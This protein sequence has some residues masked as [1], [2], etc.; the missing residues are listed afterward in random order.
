[1]RSHEVSIGIHLAA[2]RAAIEVFLKQSHIHTYTHNHTH[3]ITHTYT[4]TK[5]GIHQWASEWMHIFSGAYRDC[6]KLLNNYGGRSVHRN[7]CIIIIFNL[8]GPRIAAR[9]K[10][11]YHF[12]QL[13]SIWPNPHRRSIRMDS[14]NRFVE[15]WMPNGASRCQS[16]LEPNSRQT[17][18]IARL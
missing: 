1:M 14:S 15:E 6:V 7:S 3:T 11:W 16:L 12:T 9:R 4:H 10:D 5:P 8:H 13:T 17:E 18:T 2:G